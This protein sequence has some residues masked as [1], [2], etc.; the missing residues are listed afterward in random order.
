MGDAGNRSDTGLG[1]LTLLLRFHGIAADSEQISHRAGGA[2]I[3]ITEMLRCARAL[4]LKARAIAANWLQLS[5]LALPAIA[6]CTDGSF[7]IVAKVTEEGALVQAPF[8][9]PQIIPRAQLEAHWTGRLVLMARR[10]QQ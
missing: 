4:K 8:D 6:E 1:S 5:K 7:F 9:R 3:G 2:A 10:W